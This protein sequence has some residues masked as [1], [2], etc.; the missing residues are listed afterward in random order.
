MTWLTPQLAAVAAA[1]AVPA[2]LILYFLKLKRRELEISTTL[3]WKKAIQDLQANAPFQ[4]LRRNLL[5]FLQLLALAA[6]LVALGQPEV[7]T[8]SAQGSK[9]VLLIDR[10]ASMSTLDAAGEKGGAATRLEQA[11]LEA[12]AHIDAMRERS[13]L[14]TGEQDEAMVIA[15]DAGAEVVQTWTADKRRLRAAVESIGPTAA[16]SSLDEAARL[17]GAYSQPVFIEARGL[18]APPGAPIHLWSDGRLPDSLRVNVRETTPVVFRSIGAPDTPNVAVTGL[19]AQRSYDRP[20]RASVF[21][22]LQNAGREE[23]E[24]EIEFAVDGIVAAVRRVRVPGAAP[25]NPVAA[26]SEGEAGAGADVAWRAGESGVVFELDRAEGALVRARIVGKDSLPIDNEAWLVLPPARRL[27]VLYVA[28][29]PTLLF[30][31]LGAQE[32]SRLVQATPSQY[33]AMRRDG[34]DGEFDV[35]VLDGWAPESELPPGR[36]LVVG[37]VPKVAGISAASTPEGEPEVTVVVDWAREH[38]AL[39]AARLDNLTIAEAIPITLGDEATTL[40]QAVSGPVIVETGGEGVRAIVVAFDVMKS[41]WVWDHSLVLFVAG[42][43]RR[44]AGVAD[45]GALNQV[46]VGGTLST[47]VP[48]GAAGVVLN[49]PDGSTVPL[50]PGAD[51]RVTYGPLRRSGVYRLDWQGAAGADDRAM[52]D[53]VSRFLVANLLDAQESDVGARGELKLASGTVA[54]VAT[55]GGAAQDATLR[56]WPWLV[57]AAL[58]IVMLEWFVYNRKVFV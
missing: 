30:D 12:L 21:V 5:L 58:A 6:A 14:G 31:A 42:A 56:M 39:R 45:Q 40:V 29:S 48:P 28:I 23:R 8:R 57:L 9:T 53:R 47:R 50:A 16:T 49:L 24:A 52:G 46:R 13:L 37:A 34:T 20:T 36:F 26:D 15:F 51:G 32:L 18:V 22:G 2:L 17:A 10:S 44:L 7:R 43:V 19:R 27:A 11:K 35:V 25:E 33:Q 54:A 4:T 38:P 55:P 3:L 41:N 1:I